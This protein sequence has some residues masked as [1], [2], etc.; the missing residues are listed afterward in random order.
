MLEFYNE[1]HRW[2]LFLLN[3]KTSI[4]TNKTIINPY[5]SLRR[6]TENRIKHKFKVEKRTSVNIDDEGILLE[7]NVEQNYVFLKEKKERERE[8]EEEKCLKC[9]LHMKE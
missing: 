4:K 6:K 5:S 8:G 2:P 1:N 3:K 7:Y 9:C